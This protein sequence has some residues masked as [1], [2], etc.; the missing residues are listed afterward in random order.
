MKK[1]VLLVTNGF[2]FGESE[3]SFLGEEVKLLAEKFDLLVLAPENKDTLL[4]PAEGIL[5][6]ER[7]RLTSFRKNPNLRSIPHVFHYSALREAWSQTNGFASAAFLRNLKQTLYFRFNVWEMEQKIG[8]L[9]QSEKIDLVYTYWC[10]ECTLA[11]VYLK[12][13]FPHLKV[14]TRFHGMDLYEERAED[15]W[16]MFRKKIACGADGL[17]FACSYGRD[18][19]L[20]HWGQ[21]H[22]PKSHIFYLGST[23]RGIPEQRQGDSLRIISCS[24]LIPLK[25]VDVIIEGLALLPESVNVEWTLFGDGTEREKLEKLACDR[26]GSHANI[27]WQFRGFVPNAALTEDYRA[28]APQ[29]FITTSS[30]EGGAPVSIQE[31]FSMGIPAIGTA[32]GGIPDLIID[33]QTGYLLPQKV[34]PA[35]V[36]SAIA[37]FAALPN[38]QKF[39]MSQAA[40]Q[41]WTE[42]FDAKKNAQQFTKYLLKLL[43]D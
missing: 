18:Y 40:R 24:N 26:L 35:H 14:I 31:A 30:T 23:D 28:I 8:E 20:E 27:S 10:S 13:R 16:Q 11:A 3:R 19:F 34:E 42:N 12:K 7:F 41:R 39:Q 29:L 4:Y 25:Q 43:A 1:R 38:E 15:G 17:C 33:G 6:I 9:V 2:P 22:T 36:A 32:V 5:R 21:K 37:R